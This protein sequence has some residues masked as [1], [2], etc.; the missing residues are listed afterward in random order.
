MTKKVLIMSGVFAGSVL[1]SGVLF[2]LA[3]KT[4]ESA[5]DS[6]IL[7]PAESTL[8]QAQFHQNQGEYNEAYAL[9]RK[10]LDMKLSPPLRAEAAYQMGSLFADEYF[11][12]GAGDLDGADAYLQSAY[13]ASADN[14][15]L[16]LKVGTKLLDIAENLGEVDT[17]KQLIDRLLSEKFGE[18][19]LLG[20]WRRR[21]DFLFENAQEWRELQDALLTAENVQFTGWKWAAMLDE[22]R[23]R[24][25]ERLMENRE[26]LVQYADALGKSPVLLREE[27]YNEIC[28]AL[29]EMIGSASDDELGDLILRLGS[30]MALNEDRDHAKQQLSYYL[31]T[32]P[33]VDLVGALE[34]VE[35]LFGAGISD[36]ELSH[37]IEMLQ[38]GRSYAL[39]DLDDKLK[40]ARM[41]SSLRCYSDAVAVLDSDLKFAQPNGP[42][43]AELFAEAVVLY[44]MLG[45]DVSARQY[46]DELCL[47]DGTRYLPE[48][49]DR[50]MTVQLE[51]SQ[52]DLAEAWGMRYLKKVPR[53]SEYFQSVLLKLFDAVY[54]QDNY[55]LKNLFVGALAVQSGAEDEQVASV[56]LRMADSIENLGL[57]KLAGSYY[58]RVGLLN[59]FKENETTD[60]TDQSVGE[61]AMLGK[62][63]CLK[64]CGDGAQANRLFRELVHRSAS[65]MVRSEIAV[66]WAELALNEEQYMEAQR[67]YDLTDPYMLSPELYARYQLGMARLLNAQSVQEGREALGPDRMLPLFAALPENERAQAV[68][69]YFNAEFDRLNLQGDELAMKQLIDA[70]MT[71]D[72]ADQ[73]PVQSYVLRLMFDDVTLDQI[74]DLNA[75][76]RETELPAEASMQDLE[77]NVQRIADLNER[78]RKTGKEVLR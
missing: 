42:R 51:R 28:G 21:F 60:Q 41:L 36:P 71:S 38:A 48:S 13:E 3:S 20:L 25:N 45:D 16:R 24:T 12:T 2:K 26:W 15:V 73:I 67:R 29:E 31:E 10:V 61:M 35:K 27:L 22:Y 69:D 72:Y 74:D 76:L 63:R 52:Y 59:L 78:V 7:T 40:A 56:I 70:A 64:K 43:S 47:S 68:V 58:S 17:F 11:L 39:L 4:P 23:L 33:V 46:M 77:M 53:A 19:E 30:V 62:G 66:Y 9:L 8:Q 44:T 34:F 5:V 32:V 54:W 1:V 55:A 18:Q 75:L 49:L 6:S 50:V 57:Y 37:Y 14:P 65:P